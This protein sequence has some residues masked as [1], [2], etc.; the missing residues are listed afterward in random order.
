M[1]TEMANRQRM[2]GLRLGIGHEAEALMSS[3]GGEAYWVARR[4]AEEASSDELA[5][6][7]TGVAGVIARKTGRRQSLLATMFQ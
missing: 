5:R 1:G 2:R 7:W 6:D 3:L 4:R